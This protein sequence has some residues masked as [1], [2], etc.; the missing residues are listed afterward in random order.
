MRRKYFWKT[1]IVPVAI[2]IGISIWKIAVI[3]GVD[4]DAAIFFGVIS[5]AAILIGSFSI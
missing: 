5:G 2:L 1:F 3:S 4:N